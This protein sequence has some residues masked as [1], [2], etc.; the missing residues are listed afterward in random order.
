MRA[1]LDI[2][3]QAGVFLL[4]ALIA[5]LIFSMG[6]LALV[7]FQAAAI[8]SVSEAKYR[9]DAS[10]HANRIIGQMWVDRANLASYGCDP[11]TTN[12]GNAKTRQWVKGI[13]SSAET[14]LP[15]VTD[16]A[17]QPSIAIAG[18]TVTVTVRWQ[19]PRTAV[20]H[21][22]VATAYISGP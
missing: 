5:I 22:H 16:A 18:N 3:R 12:N 20:V 8:S 13:Q 10:F 19:S 6:I 7:G 1:H 4:E 9:T 2:D 14:G 11:C 17:N 21:S 15:G